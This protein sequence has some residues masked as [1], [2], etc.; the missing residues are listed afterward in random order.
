MGDRVT[1]QGKKKIK[2]VAGWGGLLSGA[3]IFGYLQGVG[4]E[5]VLAEQMI[6]AIREGD[7]AKSIMLFAVFVLIWLEVHGLKKAVDRM[8]KTISDGFA[9]GDARFLAAETEI[10]NLK[11][12]LKSIEGRLLVFGKQTP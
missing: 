2:K 1:D 10:T 12:H 8:N 11:A 5:K 7:L 6:E 3:T 9:A 4:V